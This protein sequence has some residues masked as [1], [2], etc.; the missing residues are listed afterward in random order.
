M[1]LG[2]ADVAQL[3]HDAPKVAEFSAQELVLEDVTCLQLTAELPNSAREAL[4]PPGLHPTITA[5]LSLQ[6]FAVRR[7]AWGAFNLALVRV[8]CRSGVRARGFTVAAIADSAAAAGALRNQLGFPV[9]PGNVVLRH[10]Y[11][12]VDLQVSREGK[13]IAALKAVNPEPL[14]ASDVQ[15]TG[16]LNLAHTPLGLR[17]LQVES[18]CQPSQV[19]RLEPG[20]LHFDG[21]GW[22]EAR[23]QPSMVI[24]CAV[25]VA[26]QW[27][28]PPLRFVCK[29]DE[30][31]FTGTETIT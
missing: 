19:E 11:D 8:S 23:L 21:A 18:H 28:F 27:V 13:R 7:S 24:A 25:V 16:T 3:A 17:L 12:G 26:P 29:A 1:L 5:A 30:L 31:A 2:T 10:G 4:L 20:R 15:F 9:N 6:V 22:G 14:S